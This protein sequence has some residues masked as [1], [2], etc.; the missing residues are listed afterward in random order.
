MG[1]DEA[2]KWQ[3]FCANNFNLDALE[4]AAGGKNGVSFDWSIFYGK[5]KNC[6]DVHGMEFDAQ[7]AAVL[8]A[9]ADEAARRA[10]ING[11]A[12]SPEN[13]DVG[14]ESAGFW[15]TMSY[16]FGYG[17]VEE[18]KPAAAEER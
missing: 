10:G 17:G 11:D 15:G 14:E 12:E 4:T 18:Q 9:E 7:L 3:S 2:A 6:N 1:F 8:E 5:R 16:A 13:A